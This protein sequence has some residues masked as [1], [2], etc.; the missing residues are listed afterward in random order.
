MT[1]ENDDAG[2]DAQDATPDH[3]PSRAGDAAHGPAGRSPVHDRAVRLSTVVWGAILLAIGGT[4]LA[5]AAGATVDLQLALIV[6]LGLAGLALLVG[7]LVAAVRRSNR[8]AD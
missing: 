2:Q 6:G 8:T 1:S 4:L 5:I 3:G 7:S